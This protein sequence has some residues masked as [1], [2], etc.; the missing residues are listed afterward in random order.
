MGILMTASSSLVDLCRFTIA[1]MV[2]SDCFDVKSSKA[3]LIKFLGLLFFSSDTF[4][5]GSLS[6]LISGWMAART[7]CYSS[8]LAVEVIIFLFFFL[9]LMISLDSILGRILKEAGPISF[10]GDISSTY[11]TITPLPK[12]PSLP[13]TKTSSSMNLFIDPLLNP[14]IN[15]Y[16]LLFVL[17]TFFAESYL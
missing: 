8:E 4:L 1:T 3:S 11:S 2:S 17:W 7:V 10:L 15:D 6:W 9:I 13:K 5:P 12:F 16:A 14:L